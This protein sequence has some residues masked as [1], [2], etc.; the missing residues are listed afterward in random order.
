MTEGG[1]RYIQ[2]FGDAYAVG[3]A[4]G[5]SV[6]DLVAHN[7]ALYFRRM[8]SEAELSRDEV[9]RRTAVYWEAVGAAS[10]EF[11]A[12]VEG[13][14]AGCGQPLLE[15]AAINFRYEFLYGEFSRIG[16]LE[17]GGVPSPAGEC[18]AFTVLPEAASDRHLRIG[19][20]WDWIPGVAGLV[21]HA[22]LPDGPRVLGFTEAGIAGAKIGMNSEGI[23]LV[24]NGLLSNQDEWAR[25]GLP[26]HARTWNVLR[27]RTLAEAA[28]AAA[29]GVHACSANF[30]IARVGPSGQGAAVD[31][32]AAPTGTCALS[33]QGGLLAHANHFREP[34]RL[35]VWQPLVE[36]RRS[37]YHRCVRME[38]LL[39][40]AR[41]R[42]GVSPD[43]LRMALRDH[44]ERPDS[45]CRHPNP[46]LPEDERYETVISTIMDL[47]EG[48]MELAA[49]PPCRAPYRTYRI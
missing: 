46:N 48:T 14:A 30:L 6:P 17:L 27:S 24:V 16:R 43:D 29:D 13:I 23:G 18:T 19:Q 34:D 8:A 22:T 20:N 1:L 38:R 7:V 11:G 44:D 5:R 26:F 28:A 49:G 9:L 3:V 42:G 45:V 32:E 40:D 39:G 15:V 2:V 21:L 35:G 37:T 33:P 47:H 36:D 10:P 12:M 31:I 4:H 25:L 41:T